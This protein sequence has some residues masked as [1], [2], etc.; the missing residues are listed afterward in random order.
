MYP[1]L[2]TTA[3]ASFLIPCDLLQSVPPHLI[4]FLADRV[5]PVTAPEHAT[6]WCSFKFNMNHSL[7]ARHVKWIMNH[8]TTGGL[9]M[10]RIMNNLRRTYLLPCFI[11]T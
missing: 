7:S 2:I 3:T 1:V 4:P 5:T 11:L 6:T 8:Q 9:Q 10:A